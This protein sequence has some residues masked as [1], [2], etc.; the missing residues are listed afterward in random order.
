MLRAC[1]LLAGSSR[2]IARS[3]LKKSFPSL[4]L[5]PFLF[6]PYKHIIADRCLAGRSRSS[7]LQSLQGCETRE[8]LANSLAPSRRRQSRLRSN[9]TSRAGIARRIFRDEP[10]LSQ[11]RMQQSL[12]SC[13]LSQIEFL[14]RS[15]PYRFSARGSS[16]GKYF[17]GLRR[18]VG[19]TTSRQL[20]KV[21]L[22]RSR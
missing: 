21:T 8:S 11:L 7:V 4:S 18:R 12:G 9:R 5:S 1:I 2:K 13:E 16:P 14:M 20:T 17:Y 6:L 15:V 3:C 22:S 19:P 10:A